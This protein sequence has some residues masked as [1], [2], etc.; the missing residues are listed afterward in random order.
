MK[1]SDG[2]WGTG[3]FSAFELRNLTKPSIVQSTD[4]T[5]GSLS[6][7]RDELMDS[8][9]S[10]W[11]SP[12]SFSGSSPSSN[13]N[14]TILTPVDKEGLQPALKKLRHLSQQEND[15]QSKNVIKAMDAIADEVSAVCNV[16]LGNHSDALRK[17][18]ENSAFVSRKRPSLNR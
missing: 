4:G 12:N 5:N 1:P 18:N 14:S 8:N 16:Q 13:S 11:I 9:S 15:T 10:S 17:I 3:V 2:I 6:L 7:L